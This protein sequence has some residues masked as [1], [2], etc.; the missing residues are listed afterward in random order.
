MLFN[1]GI[2]KFQ[3]CVVHSKKIALLLV[4][5]IVSSSAFAT[6]KNLTSPFKSKIIA[7]QEDSSG[8]VWIASE[9]AIYRYDGFDFYP[10]DLTK[11]LSKADFWLTDF[12]I[13]KQGMMYIATSNSGLLELDLIAQTQPVQ[14]MGIRDKSIQALQ[15]HQ[16]VLWVATSNSLLEIDAGNIT[17]YNYPEK[18]LIISKMITHGDQ[19]LVLASLNKLFSFD[20][21][22][23][24]FTPVNFQQGLSP[25]YIWTISELPNNEILVSTDVALFESD[26]GLV[27]WKVVPKEQAPDTIRTIAHDDERMWFGV[28]GKGLKLPQVDQFSGASPYYFN[29]ENSGLPNNGINHLFVDDN[30]HVWLGFFNGAL[31][32]L[33]KNAFSFGHYQGLRQH[34]GCKKYTAKRISGVS[35][36]DNQ[37]VWLTTVDKFIRLS[38]SNDSCYIIDSPKTTGQS[39]PAP[40][41]TFTDDAG[42]NWAYLYRLGL[43]KFSD[44]AESEVIDTH[45]IPDQNQVFYGFLKQID[46]GFLFYTSNGIVLYDWVNRRIEKI[47]SDDL[48]LVESN[49][50]DYTKINEQ[51]FYLATSG[52]TVAFLTGDNSFKPLDL[53]NVQLVSKASNAIYVDSKEDVW[54]G[55]LSSGLYRFNKRFELIQHYVHLDRLKAHK[56]ITNIIEDNHQFLWVS[57]DEGLIKLDLNSESIDVFDQSDGLQDRGFSLRTGFKT[58]DGTIYLGGFNGFN[59]FNPQD[60]ETN[61][62]PPPVVITGFKR[63]NQDIVPH[64]D[65][66]GFKIDRN[67]PHVDQMNLSYQDYVMSFQFVALD[68][69]NPQMNQYAYQLEGFDP[70]WNYTDGSNRVATY[71]NLPSGNY[72]FRVKGSNKNGVW[73]DKGVSIDLKVKPAPWLTWWA[74]SSY[75]LMALLAVYMYVQRKISNNRKIA[76]LLRVEVTEKT[77]QLNTQKQ[78]VESLLVK[79]NELFSNVSHEFR[80]P[81]TLI[82][83]PIKDLLAKQV[84]QK[85]VKSLNLINRNANRLLSL[86]EQLLQIARVSDF[87]NIK[88]TPQNTLKQVDALVE[89]FQYMAGSK[90]INLQL[91]A[92]EQATIDVTDQ[93]IDAVLGNLISNAIKY[94]QAKG[95][96][97][98]MSMTD[99]QTLSLHVKDNGQGLTPEQQRDIF[100]RF[101]RLD[102][103]QEIEGIG[104]GLSVVEELVKVNHS[105]IE[106]NSMLGQ[107]S[108]FIVR[109]PLAEALDHVQ[110][111]SISSLVKQLQHE[112]AES[113]GVEAASSDEPKITDDYSLNTVLVIEDNS[114]MREHIVSIVSPHYNCLAAENGVK[115][116]AIAISSVPDLIISDVMMPEMDGFKVARGI[117]ADE[118]TSHIPLMLLTALND[119]TNRIKGWRENVDAYM[120]KPFD[121]DELLIQL[122]NMLTIRDIL[123]RKAGELVKKGQSVTAALPKKDQEFIDKLIEIIKLN[124]H[125]PMLNRAEIA[126]KMAVSDRQLQRKT[127]ALVDQNP[128]DMLREL[129]LNKAKE[130]LKDGHQV[131]LVADNCGFNSLS[132]F[133]QCF[134]AHSGMSPK[135]YQNKING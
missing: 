59:A 61:L 119:K 41:F 85:D 107:G 80:T 67:P 40:L 22:K 134:K 1:N 49:I 66:D 91:I 89:S 88:T 69:A 13:T 64:I 109:I 39:Q 83:G 79:K 30:G 135:Q 12:L 95:Q 19:G 113:G 78:K 10:I 62:S 121:R 122:D 101:K 8:F 57:S 105:K 63:F 46:T 4:L 93:F 21:N 132:Y 71:T 100:K 53:I 133:S 106:V 126:N 37:N 130:L 32:F 81:L 23:K 5:L 45:E 75:V 29:A 104:I 34:P 96:I 54:V 2:Q 82:L 114:D 48:S 60:I 33:S 123:K 125:N 25:N 18:E 43:I 111:T 97:Q 47:T 26:G 108:E 3:I 116:V 103:H 14:S 84:D 31:S 56:N 35:E 17:S 42:S 15:M 11:F 115:G 16:D 76:D 28:T 129:R 77:K 117:R 44:G 92:N 9:D 118:R 90:N 72:T 7:F 98:V 110:E 73:N 94:T 112:S 102:S 131:S 24:F 20:F 127:K 128:M 52:G 124:Y 68:Y 36:D 87:E 51:L 6:F 38:P 70:D 55:T 120:T 50:K 74:L 27:G 65:Y 58:S 86:V 99:S